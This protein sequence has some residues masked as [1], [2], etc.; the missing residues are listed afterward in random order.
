MYFQ[1]Y[2][3]MCLFIGAYLYF[4]L[5]NTPLPAFFTTANTWIF[6]AFLAWGAFQSGRI[7]VD[8]A[9][10]SSQGQMSAPN[11]WNGILLA[12]LSLLPTLGMSLFMI[13]AGF[14]TK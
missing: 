11:A 1:Q 6:W 10:L 5:T 4:Q 9:M 3:C 12:V 2:A 7:I 14:L 13:K 8:C